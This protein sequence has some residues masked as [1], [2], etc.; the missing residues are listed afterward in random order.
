MNIQYIV[1]QLLKEKV[2]AYPTEAVFGLGCNPNSQ[3]AV[4][5]L[6]IL[7]QRPVEKGLILV[8]PTLAYLQPFI[9]ETHFESIHWQRL[10]A[11]YQKPVT[12]IVPAKAETASF[13]TG[14]FNSI[15]IRISSH[16][17]I[18][19]LCEQT[20]FALTSTSANLTGLPPCKT[21]QEVKL[22]FGEDFPVL[23]MPIGNAKN[24]SEIRNLF[25]NQILRQG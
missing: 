22:Q 10:Q 6:L 9:D 5:K 21:E 2:V 11:D 13:L 3:S 15:A 18:Q 23:N 19:Y 16:P 14:Q 7:K 20:G 1:D 25:T 4:E 8:A 17:A 24:P 12:W